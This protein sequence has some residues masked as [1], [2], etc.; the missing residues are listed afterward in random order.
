MPSRKFSNNI[1]PLVNL[2]AYDWT[3]I[4]S[5]VLYHRLTYK[6]ERQNVKKVQGEMAATSLIVELVFTTTNSTI[7]TLEIIF[8]GDCLK[9]T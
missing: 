7:R 9:L 8:I 6:Q 5:I 3:R 1:D 2:A 4:L